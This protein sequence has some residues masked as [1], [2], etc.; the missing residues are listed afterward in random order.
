MRESNQI[1]LNT[2]QLK[3]EILKDLSAQ[4]FELTKLFQSKEP[5]EYLTRKEVA[6]LCKV[7]ISTVSNWKNE[8]VLNA[9]ALGG[10]VYYKRSEIDGLMV[11]IN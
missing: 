7:H 1:Q 10:R 6:K 5:E 4:F 9:Y 3:S 11:K 8:G 2:E